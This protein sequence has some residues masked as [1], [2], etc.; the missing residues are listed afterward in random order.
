MEKNGFHVCWSDKW[1]GTRGLC[2]GTRPLPVLLCAGWFYTQQC[3]FPSSSAVTPE[4]CLVL[5]LPFVHVARLFAAVT[6]GLTED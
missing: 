6:F 1:A 5:V 3:W 2:P 4:M